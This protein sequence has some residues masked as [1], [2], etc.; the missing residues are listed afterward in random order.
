MIQFAHYQTADLGKSYRQMLQPRVDNGELSAAEAD[1]FTEQYL[2]E[3]ELQ[4]LSRV[5]G[6]S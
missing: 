6:S 5:V 3:V 1:A 4:Y 2:A